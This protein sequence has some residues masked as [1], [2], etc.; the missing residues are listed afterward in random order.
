[1]EF[2]HHGERNAAQ[3]DSDSRRPAPQ[4]LSAPHAGNP[5]WKGVPKEPAPDVKLT[6]DGQLVEAGYGHG[7]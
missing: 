7:V 3:S 1:M 2:Q 5:S 6:S 4:T